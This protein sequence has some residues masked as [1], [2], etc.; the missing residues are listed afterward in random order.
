MKSIAASI[1]LPLAAALLLAPACTGGSSWTR[2]PDD[3]GGGGSQADIVAVL[4]TPQEVVVPV[5]EGVQLVA[6][7]I[8]ADRESV[9]LTASADWSSSDGAVLSVSNALDSEGLAEGLSAGTAVVGA[10]VDGIDAPPLTVTVTAAGV[11]RLAVYPDELELVVGDDVQL[12]ASAWFS[13][14]SEADAT[15]QVRWVT[16]DGTVATLTQEG[17]LSAAGEG[18]TTV[19]AQWDEVRSDD[20]AVTVGAASSGGGGGGGGT[21][22]PANLLVAAASGSVSGGVL[23][24]SVTLQNDGETAA[25]DFWVDVFVDRGTPAVGDLGDDFDLV[26]YLAAGNTTTLEFQVAV[27]DGS[28]SVAVMAD[29]NDDVDESDEGDNVLS[30]TVGS[31]SGGGSSS[32]K[33]QLTIDYFDFA[34]DSKAGDVYYYVDISNVGDTAAGDF[35]VDVWVDRTDAP[36]LY[37]DG[38]AWTTVYGLAAGDTTYADFLIEGAWCYYCWSWVMIDGYDAVDESNEDDNVEGPL[39]VY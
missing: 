5:G 33:A 17:L 1:A 9:D 37:D 4:I 12:T 22:G 31:S 7:G 30:T 24:L 15:R 19:Y 32:D 38:D 39:E 13:D 34:Y 8:T 21:T 10:T 20:V 36:A 14:G 16:A 23:D 6:T 18:A 28:H 35:Y 25:S 26:S 11:D 2:D 27:G 29:T 3:D